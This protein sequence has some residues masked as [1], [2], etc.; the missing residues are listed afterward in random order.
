MTS[1]N[2]QAIIDIDRMILKAKSA[3]QDVAKMSLI[4]FGERLIYRSPIGNPSLWKKQPAWISKGY[5]P[6]KFINNWHLGVDVIPHEVLYIPD[7]SG[8]GSRI[9]IRQA[10][11]RFPVGKMYYFANNL[12]YARALEDGHS[13]QAPTGVLM[14]TSLEW[15][16]IVRESEIRYSNGERPAKKADL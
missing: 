7:P 13:S 12:P 2:A 4:E 11:P 8:E 14:L 9:R 5:V 1:I 6:G 10:I 15:N 16:Q 3:L